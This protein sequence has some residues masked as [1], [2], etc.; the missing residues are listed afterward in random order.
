MVQSAPVDCD[1]LRIRMAN[2]K[3]KEIGNAGVPQIRMASRVFRNPNEENEDISASHGESDTQPMMNPSRTKEQQSGFQSLKDSTNPIPRVS[4]NS[5]KRTMNTT[6]VVSDFSGVPTDSGFPK[7]NACVTPTG[8]PTFNDSRVIDSAVEEVERSRNPNDDVTSL[9]GADYRVNSTTSFTESG[10]DDFSSLAE[11]DG[12]RVSHIAGKI[13]PKDDPKSGMKIN[14][15][16]D[17]P[18]ADVNKG[19]YTSF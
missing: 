7:S 9:F 10:F 2:M 11:G 16:N 8:I 18:M 1:A 14:C 13:I 17:A 6:H 19:T 15:A 3:K 12:I 4:N 5:L